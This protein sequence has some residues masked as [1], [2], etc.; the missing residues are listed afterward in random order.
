MDFDKLRQHYEITELATDVAVNLQ[1]LEWRQHG[2]E[3]E[4]LADEWRRMYGELR[5][6]NDRSLGESLQHTDPRALYDLV[7]YAKHLGMWK[8]Y[9]ENQRR[10]KYALPA[11]DGNER[12]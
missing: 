9:E 12:P 7:R 6:L 5:R 3:D 4:Q 2:M 11:P 8:G 10:L 1:E